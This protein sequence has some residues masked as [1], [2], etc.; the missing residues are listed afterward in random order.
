M[1]NKDVLA[2]P[3]NQK[4]YSVMFLCT[5]NSARSLIA[6][7]LLNTAGAGRFR[8]FSAGSAPAGE[9]NPFTLEQIRLIGYA[10]EYLRSKSWSEYSTP[11]A[12]EMDFVITVCNTA[13]GEVPP[14]WP[15]QPVTANWD[16]RDPAAT[17]G[18]DREIRSEYSATCREIR[19]RVEIFR[20][21]PTDAL[22]E[23][24]LQRKIARIAGVMN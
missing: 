11:G 17:R 13:G 23:M 18:S 15:G 3:A 12:P 21:L 8:A 16:F 10:P 6:E 14:R 9:V 4:T 19:A 20:N 1:E 7:A 2:A 22:D 24:A 5:E